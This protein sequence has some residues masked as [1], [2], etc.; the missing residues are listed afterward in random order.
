MSDTP[1]L[2]KEKNLHPSTR[3]LLGNS[4]NSKIKGCHLASN[5]NLSNHT[6]VNSRTKLNL[7]SSK[8]DSSKKKNFPNFTKIPALNSTNNIT[9]TS[10][11]LQSNLKIKTDSSTKNS[12]GINPIWY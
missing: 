4:S 6:P 9:P 3:F 7:G 12:F 5:H 1:N 2:L 10:S 11:K 8:I